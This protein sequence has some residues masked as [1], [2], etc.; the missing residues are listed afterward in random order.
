MQDD[1]KAR[2]LVAWIDDNQER[3]AREDLREQG[4]NEVVRA[5][6]KGDLKIRN[7]ITGDWFE[8]PSPWTDADAEHWGITREQLAESTIPM[9]SLP[10]KEDMALAGIARL[11]AIRDL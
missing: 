4:R 10:P 2:A 6:L 7:A 3:C 8:I 1:P 5:L 9:A 11:E